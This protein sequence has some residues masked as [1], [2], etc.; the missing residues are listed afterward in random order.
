MTENIELENISNKL[1]IFTPTLD[2]IL[3][4]T[5]ENTLENMLE[6]TPED[7]NKSETSE[8]SNISNLS[9]KLIIDNISSANTRHRGP[10]GAVVTILI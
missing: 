6:N 10:L 7:D 9:S 4:N 1:S 5:L 3:V 8:T 2:N